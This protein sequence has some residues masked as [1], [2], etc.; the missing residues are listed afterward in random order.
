MV[1]IITTFGKGSRPLLS[2]VQP[3]KTTQYL[4]GAH[5]TA[6]SPKMY[7]QFALR[8]HRGKSTAPFRPLAAL[9]A[10]ATQAF[11]QETCV[12]PP[13]VCHTP[14]AASGQG[15]NGGEH[16]RRGTGL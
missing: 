2:T 3:S 1:A 6:C 15:R 14:D 7:P 13:A 12:P 9:H 8:T 10:R 16:C 11:F 5:P 4:F